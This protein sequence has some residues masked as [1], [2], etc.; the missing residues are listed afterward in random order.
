M[1]THVALLRGVNVGGKHPL[2]M[3]DLVTLFTD[4]GCT[5]VRTYIQSGNVI[6][7]APAGVARGL[8]DL[9]S[10]QIR[11]RHGFDT[12][13]VLR[14]RDELAEVTRRNPFLEAAADANALHVMFLASQPGPEAAARLD[15]HR[16][17]G[18][19]FSLRGREVYLHCPAGVARTRLTNAY[20]DAAL[21][22]TS[23][24]RNWRTVLK[25]LELA[26]GYEG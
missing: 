13:V 23:T 4:L 11:E 26:G 1:D 12:P 24:S 19:S 21:G 10:R 6:F 2:P 8:P 5:G 14:T 18:D 3:K 7:C 16:S 15:P 25:L 22:T 20:F 9:V 17:A